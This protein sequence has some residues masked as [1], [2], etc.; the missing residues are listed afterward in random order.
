LYCLARSLLIGHLAFTIWHRCLVTCCYPALLSLCA[1]AR[2]LCYLAVVFGCLAM[3]SASSVLLL[4]SGTGNFSDD[5]LLVA[6]TVIAVQWLMFC[7][8]CASSWLQCCHKSCIGWSVGIRPTF[9]PASLLCMSTGYSQVRHESHNHLWLLVAKF[10]PQIPCLPLSTCF[11]KHVLS[12][13]LLCT[14]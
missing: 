4:S 7:F 12:I 11:I 6:V 8:N 10:W 14:C 1:L 2:G 13:R 9:C 5:S 3:F